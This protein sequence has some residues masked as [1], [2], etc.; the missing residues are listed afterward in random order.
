ME[1]KIN[2]LASMVLPVLE[3]NC[4]TEVFVI[5]MGKLQSMPNV[6]KVF[7]FENYENW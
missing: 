1:S 3:F 6:M 4:V 7:Y 5:F 2:V